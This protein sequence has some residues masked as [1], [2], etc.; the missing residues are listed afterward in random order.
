MSLDGGRAKRICAAHTVK[1]APGQ[2]CA[3]IVSGVN[4]IRYMQLKWSPVETDSD[5]LCLWDQQAGRE[6]EK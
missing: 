4:Q 3:E 6:W 5:L 2:V 1:T